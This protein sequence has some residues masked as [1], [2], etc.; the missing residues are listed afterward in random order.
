[1]YMLCYVY[2]YVPVNSCAECARHD[3]EEQHAISSYVLQKCI[4]VDGG[5]F[6]NAFTYTLLGLG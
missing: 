3:T 4:D 2:V 6:G 5:I 1:M